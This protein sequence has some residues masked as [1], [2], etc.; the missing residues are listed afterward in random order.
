M[1]AA[2]LFHD[3]EYKPRML[4]HAQAAELTRLAQHWLLV[5]GPTA[6][7]V[8]ERVVIDRLLRALPRPL[9]QA[10]GM[11]NPTTVDELVEAVELAEAAQHR[12]A[13]E[14][15]PPFGYL[16]TSCAVH[17]ELP[18]N[19]LRTEVKIN[20]RPFQAL[21]DTGSAIPTRSPLG[22]TI[23]AEPGAWP[24][25]VGIVKKLLVPVLLGRDWPGFDRLL[26]LASQP[27]SP[28][29]GPRRRP[30]GKRSRRHPA[31]LASD[32]PPSG[33][34]PSQNT[35]LYYDVFQQVTGGGA[36]AKAQLVDDRL[37]NAWA[38]VRVIEG[39]TVHPAPHPVPHFVVQNGLLYCVAQ[40][41]GEKKTLLVVPREK[42]EIV[43]ELAHAHPMAG[44]LGVQN[45]I[46]RIRDR[47]SIYHPQMDGLVAL[48][49]C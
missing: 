28:A 39:E 27:A 35:N 9:R 13:G 49:K 38:Q 40:R 32:D 22:V 42:T 19:V 29:G 45:T 6:N 37:K 14:R 26:V 30:R 16:A 47:T 15:A 17:Q 11:R 2:Q 21:L 48:T 31:L 4:A 3:W 41:R 20:G 5:G 46:Q 44:H 43:M 23:A 34:S 24:V 36:F 8:A 12:E 33:E 7:Q 1:S 10:A 18:R 25:E